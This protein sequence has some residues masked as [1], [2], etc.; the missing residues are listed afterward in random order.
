MLSLT[1]KAVERFKKILK[2]EGRENYGIRIFADGPGCCGPSL[3]LDLA[4]QAVEG[5]A[6]FEKEGLK[7]FIGKDAKEKV[8]RGTNHTGT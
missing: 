7:V 3:A 4:E 2:D 1:D 5:D 8:Q 6:T